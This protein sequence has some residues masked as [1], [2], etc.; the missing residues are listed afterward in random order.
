MPVSHALLDRCREAVSLARRCGA[1]AVEAFGQTVEAVNSTVEKNDLQIA[2]SQFE[3]ALGIRAFVG[4]SVGFAS[5]NDVAQLESACGNAVSLA[6]ISPADPHNVLPEPV[7]T[8]PI[9]GLY[10]PSAAAFTA[11][12]AVRRTADMLSLAESIDPRV[13]LNDA[14]FD[15]GIR[16][17]AI[18]NS[19]GLA[20]EERGSL[21][22][23]GALATAREGDRVSSFDFQFDATRSVAG[24]DVEPPI[25]RACEHAL[26][27]LGAETGESFRGPVLLSPNA[28]S[29][30]LVGILL[31]QLNARNALRGRSRWR[32]AIG[33]AVAMPSL[34]LVDDGHLAGGVATATFDREGVPHRRLE[35][36][37]D[38]E[39]AAFLHNT[40]T[41]HATGSG[42][43]AHAVG[44]A[45]SIPAIGPTNLSVLPGNASVDE[46]LSGMRQGL[47]VRRFSGNVDPISGDF[48]G[49][50]KAAHLV[51]GGRLERAVSGTLIAGNAFEAL[52][53]LSGISERRERVYNLTLPHIRLENVSVTAR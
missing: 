52:K 16:N 42:N 31:F 53:T 4:H 6:R 46:L 5:T 7:G 9:E 27:S 20:V 49:A 41:A 32:D 11:A 18:A 14:W 13:T 35:L 15:A 36:I 21:F 1:D 34:T 2:K 25:R 43:T 50:A 39:L 37:R 8:A 51:K 29:E 17:I 22:T 26:A 47:F 40:Y 3:T 23:Y 48:S 44:S 24:I 30:I 38:G 28:V 19:A 33:E 12:D 45:R 10:D